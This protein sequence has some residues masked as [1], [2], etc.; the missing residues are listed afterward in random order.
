M[1]VLKV[2]KNN[3]DAILPTKG[4]VDAAGFDLYTV[5]EG[6]IMP[7]QNRLFDTGL[8]F[9]V[10]EGTYGRIAP[11]SG[12]S[13]KGIMV[14]AGVVDRDYTGPV[15]IMLHNLSDEMYEVKKNDRIAQLIIEKISSPTIEEV[16]TLD[17]TERGDGGFGS[18][19]R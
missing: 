18:T 15:K 16:E 1:D 8:S 2:S 11:R 5:D 10:P 14:N 12:V 7:H 19:G 3:D 13:K 6:R 17:D 4:S 9:T